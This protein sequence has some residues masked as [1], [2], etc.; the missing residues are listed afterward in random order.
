M[1]TKHIW[2]VSKRLLLLFYSNR[3]CASIM[4]KLLLGVL[5]CRT[6]SLTAHLITPA[7]GPH[8]TMYLVQMKE[9]SRA[10]KLG[11]KIE[12]WVDFT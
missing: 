2:M 1:G 6:N 10:S 9:D 3:R 8:F 7:K 12:R 5:V 11:E 4:R